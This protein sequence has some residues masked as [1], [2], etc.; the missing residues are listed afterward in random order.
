MKKIGTIGI[1]TTGTVLSAALNDGMEAKKQIGIAAH[2]GLEKTSVMEQ[3]A[4][5]VKDAKDKVYLI[6][7]TENESDE[8]QARLTALS[9]E[10]SNLIIVDSKD[11]KSLL[12]TEAL[13]EQ[14][15]LPFK[16]YRM[17]LPEIGIDYAVDFD[18]P[19]HRNSKQSRRDINRRGF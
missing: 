2:I 16:N 1:A 10:H 4:M 17:E 13:K 3:L 18:K 8:M 9:V 11:A 14:I 7:D 5:H 15:T 19:T 6:V 12:G